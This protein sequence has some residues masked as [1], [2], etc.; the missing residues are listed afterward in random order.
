MLNASEPIVDHFVMGGRGAKKLQ[1][2]PQIEEIEDVFSICR[3]FKH[4]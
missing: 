1:I 4:K 3:F 2:D